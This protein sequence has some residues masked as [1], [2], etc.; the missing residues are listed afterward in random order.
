MQDR[1]ELKDD[2]FLVM[3]QDGTLIIDLPPKNRG[4]TVQITHYLQERGI[5][6]PIEFYKSRISGAEPLD[7]NDSTPELRDPIIATSS[8][9]KIVL[10]ALPLIDAYI[11]SQHPEKATSHP[12]VQSP[13]ELERYVIDLVG[14]Y[15]RPYI[16]KYRSS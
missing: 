8:L 16:Q 11:N 6:T 7:P 1:H 14:R 4:T 15:Q 10:F 2:E 13:A 3:F 9:D 12:E 5:E